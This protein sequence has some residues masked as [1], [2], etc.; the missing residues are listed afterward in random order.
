M[1]LLGILLVAAGILGLVYRGFDLPGEKKG[2]KIGSIEAA[3]QKKEHY[4]VP[5]WAGVVE[6]VVGAGL[7]VGGSRR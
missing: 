1:K 4:V 6:I 7:L 2:F 3:V 5:T